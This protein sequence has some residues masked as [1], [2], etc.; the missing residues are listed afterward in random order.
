MQRSGDLGFLAFDQVAQITAT[1]GAG[2]CGA[3]R[4][5]GLG[6]GIARV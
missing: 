1:V 5:G 6:A 3:P 2:C 4:Q